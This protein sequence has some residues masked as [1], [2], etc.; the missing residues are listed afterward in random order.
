MAPGT[1]FAAQSGFPYASGELTPYGSGFRRLFYACKFCGKQFGGCAVAEDF[2]VHR[3]HAVSYGIAIVL[4]K[5]AEISPLG[6]P[7]ADDTVGVFVTAT[8]TGG[9]GVAVIDFLR[10]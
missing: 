10:V 6:K 5:R 3:I 9:I 8:L 2:T 7:T 4:S 1:N